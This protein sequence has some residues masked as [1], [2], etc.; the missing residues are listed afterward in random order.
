MSQTIRLTTPARREQAKRLI[1]QAPERATVKIAPENRTTAQNDKMWAM[2]SDVSRAKPQGRVMNPK[3]WKAVFM[4]AIGKQ[5]TWE[6]A[7]DG[8]GVVCTGYRSSY[9]SVAD[10]SD[11]IAQI[12]AYAAEHG[13]ELRD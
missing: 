3:A 9:L 12:D 13:V 2:L 10:M 8:S 11:M 7:L 4:D 6:P 1:D 5:A